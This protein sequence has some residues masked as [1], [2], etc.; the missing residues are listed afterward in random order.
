MLVVHACVCTHRLWTPCPHLFTNQSVGWASASTCRASVSPP[1]ECRCRQCL[2]HGQPC[3]EHAVLSP[4]FTLGPGELVCLSL[5]SDPGQWASE[6]PPSSSHGG[7]EGLPGGHPH[8]QHAWDTRRNTAP[9]CVSRRSKSRERPSPRRRPWSPRRQGP[10][11]LQ[12]PPHEALRF[13]RQS[14][15]SPPGRPACRCCSGSS[16]AT[17][18]GLPPAWGSQITALPVF[19]HLREVLSTRV[20][21]FQHLSVFGCNCSEKNTSFPPGRCKS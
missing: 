2:V 14:A 9:M 6:C 5:F 19:T 1:R 16:E 10:S 18:P 4:G 11:R 15:P 20:K 17:H 12:P 13:P 7:R 8:M 21:S 3:R